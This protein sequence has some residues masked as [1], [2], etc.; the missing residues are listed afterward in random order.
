MLKKNKAALCV[1]L[2]RSSSRPQIVTLL[3]QV[4]INISCASSA[5]ANDLQAE[6]LDAMGHQ[7][8]PPGMHLCQ[9]PF[10]DDVRKIDVEKHSVYVTPGSSP[11]IFPLLPCNRMVS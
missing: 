2:P 9:L 4:R 7:V 11:L 6:V 5:D 10:A 1:F 8:T 3:A